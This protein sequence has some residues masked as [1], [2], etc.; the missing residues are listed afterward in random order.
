MCEAIL[1]GVQR[2]QDGL[3]QRLRARSGDHAAAGSDEKRIAALFPEPLEHVAHSGLADVQAAAG[4]SDMAFEPE[5]LECQQ[6]IEIEI[7]TIH[8][9]HN[10]HVRTWIDKPLPASVSFCP[11]AGYPSWPRHERK[12]V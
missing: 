2:R 1:D 8:R 10:L 9:E 3:R 5:R 12:A 7:T 11:D 4:A 6:K